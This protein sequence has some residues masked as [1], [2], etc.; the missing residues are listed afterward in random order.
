MQVQTGRNRPRLRT[1]RVL[2]RLSTVLVASTLL[3]APALGQDKNRTTSENPSSRRILILGYRQQKL[4]EDMQW[5]AAGIQETLFQ[6][7]SRVPGIEAVRPSHEWPGIDPTTT[8]FGDFP[9]IEDVC[10]LG[11]RF[12][13][14]RVQ[15]G[16]LIGRGFFGLDTI[17]VDVATGK[18]I[19]QE[20]LA[21]AKPQLLVLVKKTAQA[22]LRSYDSKII[23]FNDTPMKT[24]VPRSDRLVWTPEI[25]RI[26][27]DC[28]TE[29][30]AA[31]EAFCR[32]IHELEQKRFEKATAY[33][34]R[35]VELDPKY[36]WAYGARSR[37]AGI[38]RRFDDA[39]R[40]ADKA[41]EI[42]PD[43]VDPYLFRGLSYGM[44]KDYEA[45][46]REYTKLIERYP[47]NMHFLEVRI[48]F[49]GRMGDFAHGI[50]DC[51]RIL[52][53]RPGD[54]KIRFRKASL[55]FSNNALDEAIEECTSLIEE[56][57]DHAGA[58]FVRACARLRQHEYD[59]ALDDLFAANRKDPGIIEQLSIPKAEIT[60]YIRKWCEKI[61]EEATEGLAK[62]PE[63]VTLLRRR[64]KVH[65]LRGDLDGAMKDVDAAIALGTKDAD[66][67]YE[68]G[69]TCAERGRYDEAIKDLSAA[70]EE[71]P[72]WSVP[73]ISRARVYYTR[74]EYD[75]AI[76]DF[77]RAIEKGANTAMRMRGNAY[78][79][80]RLYDVAARDFDKALEYNPDDATA[81]YYRGVIYYIRLNREAALE[82][83][84][85]A[86]K[87][88][89]R[90]WHALV[91]RGILR[92]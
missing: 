31:F 79:R 27:N 45:S 42:D 59:K 16:G 62:N 80:L 28:G 56:N 1:W 36:A 3:C 87:A 25:K 54:P 40:D 74:K 75:Q 15:A 63:N 21:Y 57:E 76:M 17:I 13:T 64:A 49:Y 89:P 9:E 8:G 14:S 82:K 24:S 43:Y 47:D 2:L 29:N 84:D 85:A 10:R 51:D 11:K 30:V 37:V 32:G 44:K 18:E 6:M 65:L 58:L 71:R 38:Q 61:F 34:T 55:C 12:E 90:F 78:Y 68:R 66:L 91:M 81:L 46:V 5:E 86:V 19:A 72:D 92:G 20:S 4:P 77:S 88:R 26:L 23:M 67:L 48:N 41:T 39:I 35:A 22:I 83:F 52:A 70:I 33:F 73:Y 50:E 60:D 69:V 7:L 53:A